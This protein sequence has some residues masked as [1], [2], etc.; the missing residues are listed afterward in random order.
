M[1]LWDCNGGAAQTWT[2]TNGTLTHGGKCLDVTGGAT[3]NGTPVELWDCNGG[4]NQQWTPQ[5]DGTLKSAQS[6][7]CLDDPA[8]ATA[9]GTRLEIWDCNGGSNQ[10]WQLP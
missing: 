5:P 3:A 2:R 6:G 10:Q 1:Q 4:A 9:N 7:R 8:F